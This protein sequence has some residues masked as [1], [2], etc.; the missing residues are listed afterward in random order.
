MMCDDGVTPPTGSGAACL[1]TGA[2]G[3]IGGR[4]V[5]ELLAAGH[6]VRRL[7]RSPGKLRDHPWADRAEVVRGDVTD[8][9]S[10]RATK[11]GIAVVYYLVHALGTGS[12]FNS[13]GRKVARIFGK[14]AAATGVRRIVYLGG[15]TPRGVPERELSPHLRSRAEVGRIFLEAAVPATVLR[16]AVIIGSGSA[17]FEML[18][19]LTERL[20]GGAGRHHVCGDDAPLCLGRHPALA[21]DRACPGR[22]GCPASGSA[23]SRRCRVRS[24]RRTSSGPPRRCT[25]MRMRASRMAATPSPRPSGLLETLRHAARTAQGDS[26]SPRNRKPARCRCRGTF[27]SSVTAGSEENPEATGTSGKRRTPR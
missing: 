8:A 24:C 23:W 6:R 26:P 11:E 22:R 9:A 4:L 7:A 21:S 17:S 25:A 2:T 14:Q 19:Y 20:P 27:P 3:Y 15:L 13:T 1:V 10:V 12:G 16:A 18:R 5:P